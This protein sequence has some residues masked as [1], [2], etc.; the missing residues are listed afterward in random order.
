MVNH[1][2]IQGRM[3]RD[4]E[5]SHTKSGLEVLG[6][7]VAWS[8]KYKETERTLFMK[9]RAWRQTAVFI[10][11]YFHNK[12]SEIL[13]EGSLETEKW[14]DNNGQN[15]SE[16]VLTVDKVHFCGKKTDGGAKT[17]E[18]P[19]AAGAEMPGTDDELPFD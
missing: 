1:A 15:R 16:T 2:V 18:A 7:T 9:C 13:L 8:E 17:E 4:C 12:G 10:D 6:F 11:K 14:T 5:L 3:I 19:K